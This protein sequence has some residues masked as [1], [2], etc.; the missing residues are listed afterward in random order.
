M[1]LVIESITRGANEASH[2]LETPISIAHMVRG[3]ITLGMVYERY[4]RFTPDDKAHFCYECKGTLEMGE[5][6]V[7]L[8]PDRRPS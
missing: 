2:V 3:G 7:K 8:M 4:Q 5:T 6:A 1:C